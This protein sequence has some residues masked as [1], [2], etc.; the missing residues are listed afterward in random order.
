MIFRILLF[1][2]SCLYASSITSQQH[3]LDSL[4]KQLNGKELSNEEKIIIYDELG[5][6]L[7][8]SNPQMAVQFADSAIEFALETENKELIV[9][10]YNGRSIPLIR[11][12]SF[13]K[14]K[15][16]LDSALK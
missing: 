9:K 4:K 8:S 5:Y 13:K 15:S 1:T 12:G 10:A 2:I 11:L 3:L 7:S 16:T 14:A 6:Q